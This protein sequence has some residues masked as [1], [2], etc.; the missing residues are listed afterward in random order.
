MENDPSGPLGTSY[1][2]KESQC[3][4]TGP[5]DIASA[6]ALVFSTTSLAPGLWQFRFTADVRCDH[7]VI[8]EVQLSN[9]GI[10][11][12]QA[13]W[14]GSQQL[15]YEAQ[16]QIGAQTRPEF[17]ASFGGTGGTLD[18]CCMSLTYVGGQV[19]PVSYIIS[20]PE[21]PPLDTAALEVVNQLFEGMEYDDD[22]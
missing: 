7:G 3:Y 9:D 8:G 12:W 16:L 11:I 5:W 19:E 2:A 22:I 10:H 4:S 15:I 21:E 1:T 18:E 6:K 14:Q 13:S 20:Q 17:S